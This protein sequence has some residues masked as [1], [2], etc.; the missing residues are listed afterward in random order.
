[1]CLVNEMRIYG[2]AKLESGWVGQGETNGRGLCLRPYLPLMRYYGKG[3]MIP[4]M[5]HDGRQRVYGT[6]DQIKDKHYVLKSNQWTHK[7]ENEDQVC[8]TCKEEARDNTSIQIL[9]ILCSWDVSWKVFKRRLVT[10][11]WSWQPINKIGCCL[12]CKSPKVKWHWRMMEKNKSSFNHMT[13]FTFCCT[14]DLG[15]MR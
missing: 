12:E 4:Q 6:H 11:N 8:E 1:M 2:Y 3:I 5:Q 15:C 10:Q 9:A 14:N 13:M 7:D